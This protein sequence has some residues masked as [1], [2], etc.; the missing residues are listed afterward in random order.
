MLVEELGQ[1]AGRKRPHLRRVGGPYGGGLGHDQLVHELP[2]VAP[3]VQVVAQRWARPVQPEQL[4]R[5]AIEASKVARHA[6]EGGP[7][8][9]RPVG[10]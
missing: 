7:D 2:R 8:E 10:A 3:F 1:H 9:V 5:L 4:R 6:K